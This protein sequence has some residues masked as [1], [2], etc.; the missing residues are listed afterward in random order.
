MMGESSVKMQQQVKTEMG[1]TTTESGEIEVDA[2]IEN[3][4]RLYEM[5]GRFEE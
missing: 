1:G 4:G 2:S 3:L 5:L